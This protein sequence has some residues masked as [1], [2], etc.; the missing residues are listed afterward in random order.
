MIRAAARFRMAVP[1]DVTL[2][3]SLVNLLAFA[4]MPRR[5]TDG[6][7]AVAEPAAERL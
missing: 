4:W 2:Q 6:T 3:L 5:P 7:R 1:F